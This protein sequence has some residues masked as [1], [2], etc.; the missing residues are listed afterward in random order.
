MPR[1]TA[2]EPTT[3]D[4]R[5]RPRGDSS[6]GPPWRKTSRAARPA[7]GRERRPRRGRTVGF[8]LQVSRGQQG[9]RT[10]ARRRPGCGARWV[11]TR[12]RR[13]CPSG[14]LDE[15]QAAMRRGSVMRTSQVTLTSPAAEPSGASKP[16]RTS[17]GG[18]RPSHLSRRTRPRSPCSDAPDKRA[19]TVTRTRERLRFPA[20]L[21]AP[22][23]QSSGPWHGAR[24]RGPAA[25]QDGSR[26]WPEC[27]WLS[28]GLAC[29]LADSCGVARQ[30]VVQLRS[31]LTVTRREPVPVRR[32]GVGRS[33]EQEIAPELAE[34]IAREAQPHE[35]PSI[36][37]PAARPSQRRWSQ[38]RCSRPYCPPMLSS[39]LRSDAD[40]RLDQGAP[41][42][43]GTRCSAVE[44]TRVVRGRG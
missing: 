27:S 16:L 12:G 39:H 25:G 10:R 5:D 11:A 9:I 8:T 40:R 44:G 35:Q 3:V 7:R 21:E 38:G 24:R 34:P 18:T 36:V 31:P 22:Q 43:S 29:R 20:A 14:R 13:L 23:K 17:G 42:P 30:V 26:D 28:A 33:L 19:P 41:C 6:P 32:R 37:R 15:E 4:E 2:R 1:T